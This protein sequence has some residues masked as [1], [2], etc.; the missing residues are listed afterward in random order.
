MDM[1]TRKLLAQL[2][3]VSRAMEHRD[4]LIW[5]ARQSGATWTQIVQATGLTRVGAMRAGRRFEEANV[6]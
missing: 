4:R 3:A 1:E 6:T 2:T 5:E